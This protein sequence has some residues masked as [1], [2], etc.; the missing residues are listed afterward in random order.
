MHHLL[1]TPEGR[2]RMAEGCMKLVGAVC[3]IATGRVRLLDEHTVGLLA[4]NA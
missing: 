1:D 4:Q 2:E 3:D